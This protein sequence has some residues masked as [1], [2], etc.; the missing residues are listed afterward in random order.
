MKQAVSEGKT[1]ALGTHNAK[2]VVMKA[3]KMETESTD[4]L[5][6]SLLFQPAEHR[7]MV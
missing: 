4:C 7:V 5:F 1:G 3:N 2:S 6:A